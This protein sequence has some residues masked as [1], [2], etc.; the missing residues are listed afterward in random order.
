MYDSIHVDLTPTMP[1]ERLSYSERLAEVRLGEAISRQAA[2]QLI[3]CSDSILPELLAA[4]GPRNAIN[5][6]SRAGATL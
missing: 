3:D 2:I 4:A 5:R 6:S 1:P